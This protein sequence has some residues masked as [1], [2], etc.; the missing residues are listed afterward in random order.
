MYRHNIL[1]VLLFIVFLVS[2]SIAEDKPEMK[3]K[4]EP[5][6]NIKG[7]I[8]VNWHIGLTDSTDND[9]R[10]GQSKDSPALVPTANQE[11]PEATSCGL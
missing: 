5:L 10:G 9:C 3:S 11:R 8:Y 1:Y 2:S 7:K 4:E 6:M